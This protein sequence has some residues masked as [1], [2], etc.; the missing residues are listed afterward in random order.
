MWCWPCP[1]RPTTLCTSACWRDSLWVV[2][3]SP[4]VLSCGNLF[5]CF[6]GIECDTNYASPPTPKVNK[7]TD[8]NKKAVQCIVQRLS[9]CCLFISVCVIL[10]CYVL[11]KSVFWYSMD[12]VLILLK[13]DN[14][15]MHLS[16]LEGFTVI[17]LFGPIHI[18]SRYTT[19]AKCSRNMFS[20]HERSY[21]EHCEMFSLPIRSGW[22]WHASR[23]AQYDVLCIHCATCEVILMCTLHADSGLR[24]K[25]RPLRTLFSVHE[26]SY[27]YLF[28]MCTKGAICSENMVWLCSSWNCS[29][30]NNSL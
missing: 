14:S 13:K 11:F 17:C 18:C 4:S 30:G 29:I 1:R 10:Y 3:L 27:M 24:A 2:F 28:W 6:P 5:L 22:K 23:S 20:V 16:M 15:T 26:R 21:Y 12:V 9:A 25:P 8:N 7:Q 19:P